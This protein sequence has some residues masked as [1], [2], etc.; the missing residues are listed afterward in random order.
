MR[1]SAI[2][3]HHIGRP[4]K[5]V[6]QYDCGLAVIRTDADS[7]QSGKKRVARDSYL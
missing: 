4:D 1:Q 2:V 7:E 5:L 3:R 6:G